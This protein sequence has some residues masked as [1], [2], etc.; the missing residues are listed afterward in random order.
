MPLSA[1][2]AARVLVPSSEPVVSSHIPLPAHQ[3]QVHLAPQP[4]QVI[5]VQVAH[6]V[7]GVVE[8][9]GFVPRSPQPFHVLS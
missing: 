8:V 1:S 5:T 9:H 2:F 4:V 7:D 3:Q 6:V